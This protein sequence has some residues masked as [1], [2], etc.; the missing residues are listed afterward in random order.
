MKHYFCS[1]GNNKIRQNTAHGYL[2]NHVAGAR[3]KTV[4]SREVMA[5]HGPRKYPIP[6]QLNDC[7]KEEN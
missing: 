6:H 3:K 4:I 2:A 5:K 7:T 1:T